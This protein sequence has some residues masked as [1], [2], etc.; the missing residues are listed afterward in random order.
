MLWHIIWTKINIHERL[1]L[2]RIHYSN[3]NTESGIFKEI[4]YNILS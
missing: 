3:L 1:F 4:R 2:V